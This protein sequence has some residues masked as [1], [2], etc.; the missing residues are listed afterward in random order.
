MPI[1][2]PDRRGD[3]LHHHEAAAAHVTALVALLLEKQPELDSDSARRVLAESAVDLGSRGRDPIYG[4]GRIDL[5]A[6]LARVLP[7][8]TARP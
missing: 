4:A 7:V 5:P 1:S 8:A 6:A 3:V 2:Y